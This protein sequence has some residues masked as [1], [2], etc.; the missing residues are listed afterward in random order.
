MVEE[1]MTS[2][3]EQTP[4]AWPGIFNPA[5]EELWV[6]QSDCEWVMASTVHDMSDPIRL[7]HLE[8]S[9]PWIVSNAKQATE[10]L[11][12][13]REQALSI[14]GALMSWRNCTVSQLQAGLSRRPVPEFDR[15]KPNLYGALCR[16]GVLNVGFSRSEFYGRVFIP[17]TWLGLSRAQNRVYNVTHRIA[18]Y[19]FPVE[20]ILRSRP[21]T[22]QYARHNT[23]ASHVGLAFAHDPRIKYTVGDGWAL[24]RSL[25]AQAV[26]EMGRHPNNV[27]DLLGFTKNGV[28]AA[29][30]VQSSTTDVAKKM[31]AWV[32]FLA[33]S[34]MSRRGV[35]CVWLLIPVSNFQ[36]TLDF[37]KYFQEAADYT[38]VTIGDPPVSARIGWATW[39]DWFDKMGNPTGGFGEY[40]DLL[41]IRRS[42][43]ADDWGPLPVTADFS[44]LTDWGWDVMNRDIRNVFG[45]D[46]STWRKPD[47]YRGDTYGFVG[48]LASTTGKDA[49]HD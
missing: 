40:T 49:D 35:V 7:H 6:R 29:I 42:M 13:N 45:W 14:I 25:D 5:D 41:G 48:G 16:A 36:T 46:T 15:M 10:M 33:H 32:D 11:K 38:G 39:N 1:V 2:E 31:E 24:F 26:S 21:G 22:H 28:T 47:F 8:L 4:P 23:F 34:P 19:G 20:S 3:S 44:R 12:S 17:Q 27:P 37:S 9:C 18:G 30:E 43:F